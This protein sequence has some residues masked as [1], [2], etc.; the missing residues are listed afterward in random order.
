M[1]PGKAQP[2]LQFWG[3]LTGEGTSRGDQAPAALVWLRSTRPEQAQRCGQERAEFDIV[4]AGR[5]PIESGTEIVD[6]RKQALG[7]DARWRRAPLL[8]CFCRE[9]EE[10]GGVA[11]PHDIRFAALFE[12]VGRIL[13]RRRQQAIALLRAGE[14]G[15][16]K[17]L[18]HESGEQIQH[19]EWIDRRVAADARCRIER[20]AASKDAQ[21]AK[22]RFL[23]VGEEVVAPVDEGPHS[24][25]AR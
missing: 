2:S 8:L 6:V 18:V 19:V 10:E 3:D 17:R 13:A 21:T 1:T 25:L 20:A 24:L 22:N 16:D 4:T 11:R 15:D 7:P 9:L 12:Q 14:F 5:C 23:F